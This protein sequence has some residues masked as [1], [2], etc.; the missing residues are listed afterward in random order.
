MWE[1]FNNLKKKTKLIAYFAVEFNHNR[2]I[3]IIYFFEYVFSDLDIN[4]SLL[5][6]PLLCDNVRL[7][8]FVNGT[9]LLQHSANAHI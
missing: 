4:A 9:F 3:M 6:N 2:Q 5:K 1:L 8:K 7:C